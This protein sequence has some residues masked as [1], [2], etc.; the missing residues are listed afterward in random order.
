M[1]RTLPKEGWRS[2]DGE[3][4]LEREGIGYKKLKVHNDSLIIQRS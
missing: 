3:K 1:N 2:W 4:T